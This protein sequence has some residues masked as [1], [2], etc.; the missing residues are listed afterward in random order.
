MSRSLTRTVSVWLT[1]LLVLASLVLWFYA[2]RFSKNLIGQPL[3]VLP[4][5]SASHPLQALYQLQ[6]QASREGWTSERW[7]LAGDLWRDAGDLTRAV[8][9]WEA[10]SADPDASLMRDRAQAYIE[11]GRWVDAADALDQLLILLPPNNTDRPWAQFQLGLI[12]A[13]Y[14]PS[15]AVELLRAAEPTYGAS[16]TNL[17]PGLAA[18]PDPTQAGIALAKVEQW[19]HAEL[20]FSHSAEPLASAYQGLA[21]DMQGKDGTRWINSAVALAPENPQVRFLQ[22]LHLRLNYDYAGSLQ[23]IIQAVALDPEN[24]A[25]Y[26]ELGRAYQLA[27]DLVTAEHWLRF[28]VSLDANFQPVLDSFYNDEVNTLLSLGLIDEA[29]FPFSATPTPE[30]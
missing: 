20:A 19:A 22:G 10:A 26:A 18:A 11:L 5:P 3:V 7:R 24:P 2:V 16:V 30:P 15:A 27:G 28:A 8:A 14:D 17:L 25:L 29:A 9:Y 21:R 4:A 12:L 1:L 13:S 23:A 6:A